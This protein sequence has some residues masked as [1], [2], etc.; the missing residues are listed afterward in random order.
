MRTYI[1][2]ALMLAA[3]LWGGTSLRAQVTGG[4][5]AGVSYGS[6]RITDPGSAFNNAIEGK[7]IRGFEAGF[8]LKAKAGPVYVKPMALYNFRTGSVTYTTANGAEGSSSS[9]A[10]FSLHKIAVPVMLGFHIIGP[11]VIEGGPTFNYIA[12]ITEHYGDQTVALGNSGLG[13]RV[14]AGLDFDNVL[15]HLSYDGAASYREG[16]N[17]AT[18]HEPYQLTLGLGI[19]LSNQTTR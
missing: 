9:T 3:L 15:I 8:F 4:L 17:K 13:Y 10:N 11:L 14:G 2:R 18:F 19:R 12:S 6:I 5:A 16:S 7:G 1:K